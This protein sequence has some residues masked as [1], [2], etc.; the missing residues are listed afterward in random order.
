MRFKSVMFALL[1]LPLLAVA[2]VLSPVIV[3]ALLLLA[4]VVPGFAAFKRT[5]SKRSWN[6]ASY[7][8]PRSLTWRWLLHISLGSIFVRPRLYMSPRESFPGFKSPFVT[9]AFNIGIAGASA[10]TNNYGWQFGV[11]ILGV[12]LQFCQQKHMWYPDEAA[13]VEDLAKQEYRDGVSAG[14]AAR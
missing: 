3:P 11:W 12:H 9:F 13:T 4:A 14:A 5:S 10:S 6:V 1:C 8:H 7:H 2:A